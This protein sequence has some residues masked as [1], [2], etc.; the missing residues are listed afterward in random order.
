M[1]NRSILLFF[2]L[3][4]IACGGSPNDESP[5]PAV[6]TCGAIEAARG[7]VIP[8]RSRR[9][10]LVAQAEVQGEFGA[11]L[12]VILRIEVIAPVILAELVAR[13]AAVAVGSDGREGLQLGGAD[14]NSS[15]SSRKYIEC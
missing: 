13:E 5:S 8:F 9:L 2:S 11:H 7:P 1:W 3:S 15:S 14:G 12:P 6:K 10:I 4:L